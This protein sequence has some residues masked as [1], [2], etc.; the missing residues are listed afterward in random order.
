MYC[1]LLGKLRINRLWLHKTIHFAFLWPCKSI[2]SSVHRLLSN[3][4]NS[5]SHKLID[6]TGQNHE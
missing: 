6:R 3:S 5:M 4:S 1:E 2:E